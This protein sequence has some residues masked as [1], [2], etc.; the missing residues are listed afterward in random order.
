MNLTSLTIE[1]LNKCNLRCAHCAINA[2]PEGDK[3]LTL[4]ETKEWIAV[5]KKFG[6][7][8]VYLSG[9]EPFLVFGELCELARYSSSLGLRVST[10]S[11]A[12]WSS[13]PDN[14]TRYMQ[15]L[16]ENGLDTLLLSF[17]WFHIN[18]GVPPENFLNAAKAANTIGIELI[19]NVIQAKNKGVSTT[20]L[21]KVFKDCKVHFK[22]GPLLPLGRASTLGKGNFIKGKK[23]DAN[24]GCRSYAR[25]L[26][27]PSGEVFACCGAYYLAGPASP[28]RLG[29]AREISFSAIVE[30][31]LN[32][33]FLSLIATFG[34]GF[35]NGLLSSEKRLVEHVRF[36]TACELCNHLLNSEDNMRIIREKLKNIF[37]RNQSLHSI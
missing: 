23:G 6:V 12:F 17:D 11:N 36:P 5:A 25:P 35:I 18:G 26:I 3:K 32:L 13:S 33:K 30:K 19:I 2:S 37:A 22:Y 15:L 16:K 31:L 24:K 1:Y 21:R 10:I 4:G 34:P 14:A 20:F 7:R 27:S 8:E 28:L 9:G 29:N